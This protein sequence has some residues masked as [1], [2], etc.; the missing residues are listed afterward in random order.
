MKISDI[1]TKEDI[2]L[3]KTICRM[4]NAQWVEIDGVRYAPPREKSNINNSIIVH[5]HVNTIKKGPE[6]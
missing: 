5:A 1:L 3:I 2:Q 6:D 4:F